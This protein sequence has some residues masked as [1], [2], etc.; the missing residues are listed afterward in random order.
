MGFRKLR[1][2]RELGAKSSR[3]KPSK[4]SHEV[5][6]KRVQEMGSVYGLSFGFRDSEGFRVQGLG[7]A[8]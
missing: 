7:R 6:S 3:I 8:F 5:L 2:F 1:R 4:R